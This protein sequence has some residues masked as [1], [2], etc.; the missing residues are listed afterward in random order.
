[1]QRGAHRRPLPRP[2]PPAC[3]THTPQADRHHDEVPLLSSMRSDRERA[4]FGAR[5]TVLRHVVLCCAMLYC[6]APCCAMLQPSL[7]LVERALAS[8]QP[9]VHAD[10]GEWDREARLALACCIDQGRRAPRPF[11]LSHSHSG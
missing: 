3:G 5:S 1:M 6:V 2:L 9:S 7:A 4:A 11:S 8:D 10:A